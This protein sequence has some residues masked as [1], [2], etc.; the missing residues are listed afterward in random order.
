MWLMKGIL[1]EKNIADCRNEYS[2]VDKTIFDSQICAFGKFGT[3]A[4]QGDS[5]GKLLANFVIF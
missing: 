4:C 3:D 5:G 2:V 1:H